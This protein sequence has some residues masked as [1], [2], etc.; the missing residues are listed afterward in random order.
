MIRGGKQRVKVRVDLGVVV[1]EQ[2]L[3]ATLEL[4][5]RYVVKVEDVIVSHERIGF[6]RV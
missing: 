1:D 5:W 3:K 2:L 4:I 6:S